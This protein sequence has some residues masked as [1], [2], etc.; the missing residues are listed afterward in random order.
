MVQRVTPL[1][2]ETVGFARHHRL[3]SDSTFRARPAS[4]RRVKPQTA[5]TRHPESA[6][7]TSSYAYC[8][9]LRAKCRILTLSIHQVSGFFDGLWFSPPLS[10]V[11]VCES[12]HVSDLARL[13]HERRDDLLYISVDGSKGPTHGLGKS[14]CL[15]ILGPVCNYNRAIGFVGSVYSS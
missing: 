13:V 6:R 8:S 11:G 12:S 7:F 9:V 4:L 14:I 5:D 3:L 15:F 10:L 2:V 1:A